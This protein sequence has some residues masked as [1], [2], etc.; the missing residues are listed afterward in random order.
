MK[1]IKSMKDI[2]NA[3]LRLRVKQLELEKEMK[4][5]WNN[6]K[7]GLTPKELLKTGIEK[8]TEKKTGETPIFYDALDYGIHYMGE[9]LS[10]IASDKLNASIH[11]NIEKLKKYIKKK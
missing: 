6:L 1:K 11:T 4:N 10:G 7:S 8:M 3:K 2:S 9:K 5:D